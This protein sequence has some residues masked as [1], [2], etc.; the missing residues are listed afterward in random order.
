MN[1]FQNLFLKRNLLVHY[2][3]VYVDKKKLD[4]E[5]PCKHTGNVDDMACCFGL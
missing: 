4:P 3:H 1:F 2:I 5:G